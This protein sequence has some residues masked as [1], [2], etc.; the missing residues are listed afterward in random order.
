[1]LIRCDGLFSEGSDYQDAVV[2]GPTD[3]ADARTSAV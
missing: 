2:G 1:M 3:A